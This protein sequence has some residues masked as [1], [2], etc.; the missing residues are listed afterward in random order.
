MTDLDS[1]RPNV[2]FTDLTS[3]S[4]GGGSYQTTIL[5]KLAYSFMNIKLPHLPEQDLHNGEPDE[6]SAEK[7]MV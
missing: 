6:Y 3:P 7:Y 4:Q 5:T 1:F 2:D